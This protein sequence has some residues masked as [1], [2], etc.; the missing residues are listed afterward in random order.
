MRTFRYDKLIRD[1]IV[2]SM[3]ANGESPDYHVCS[4]EEFV[5]ALQL[6]LAEEVS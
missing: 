4:N 5:S 2:D 3:I 1:K 6:K